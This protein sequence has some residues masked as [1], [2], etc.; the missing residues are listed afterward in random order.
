MGVSPFDVIFN[1]L[2][3]RGFSKDSRDVPAVERYANSICRQVL[4]SSTFLPC[5]CRA[6]TCVNM[7]LTRQPWAA[8]VV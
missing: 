6:R 4:D 7:R 2:T 8:Y 5:L 3:I 1:D